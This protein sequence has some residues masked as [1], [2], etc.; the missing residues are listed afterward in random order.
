MQ[1]TPLL[2]A[3]VQD[4]D[5]HLP[6]SSPLPCSYEVLLPDRSHLQLTAAAQLGR[7]Y[8]LAASAPDE[9]WGASG[10]ALKQAALTF[11]L[12]YRN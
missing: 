1:G 8:V 10:A 12:N 3:T 5:L 6:L 9:Q 7:L 2:P 4:C 11:R